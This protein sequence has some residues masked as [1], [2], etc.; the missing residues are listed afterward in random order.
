MRAAAAAVCAGDQGKFFPYSDLLYTNQQ[1]ENSGFLTTDQ[2]V[3]FGQ[4][5]GITGSKFDT[6]EQCVRSN[7]YD[8]YVR[9]Q[10]ENASKRGIHQTPTVFVNGRQLS[11][12]QVFVPSVF[13]QAVA[14]AAAAKT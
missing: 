4:D 3:E 12:E 6:F 13:E 2:L 14:D 7:R 1:G 10:A 8:G 5:A 9:R 11:N